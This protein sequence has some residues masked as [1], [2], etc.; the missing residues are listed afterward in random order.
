MTNI[1]P[2]KLIGVAEAAGPSI[3][4]L[5][6]SKSLAEIAFDLLL[7]IGL[8]IVGCIALL[9]VIYGGVMIVVSQ[10]DPEKLTKAKRTL[11]WAITGVII[12]VISYGLVVSLSKVIE[13][14]L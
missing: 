13:R 14:I 4:S 7:N 5:D 2:T 6:T 12:V 3:K 1:D 9:A 11:F 8:P 10:G